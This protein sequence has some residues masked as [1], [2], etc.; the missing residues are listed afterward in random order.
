MSEEV[1]EKPIEKTYRWKPHKRAFE[2]AIGYIM[3]RK[4]GT[5]TSIRTGWPKVNDAIADGVEWNSTT[6]IAGRPASGKTL[7][8]DQLIRDAFKL[9]KN[10]NFR[11][12]EFQFEMVG[13]V[14]AMRSFSS[15]LDKSYKH[16]CSADG[17]IS[18]EDI[19]K[20]ILNPID[21]VDEPCTVMELR[22]IIVEYMMLHSV[23]KKDAEGKEY[24]EFTK[25]II[26]LDHSLL[27]KKAPFEKD[28]MDTLFALGEMLTA[29]KRMFPIAFIIL[30]QLNREIDK[31]E[32]NEE[33]KY[34]NYILESDLYGADAL[35]Q[36]ADTVIGVDRPGKR[37][38][39]IYGPD[40]YLIEDINVLIF[41]FLKARNGDTRLSFMKA[42]FHKMCVEEMDTPGTQELKI[43]TRP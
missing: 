25:T 27:V 13:R 34:G 31:P 18:N 17:V 5:I 4:Q 6:V 28:R 22:D 26:T 33:G 41:H 20:C 40:K 43:R 38:L 1:A 35:L 12:L 39:W 42:A 19:Q 30:S 29:L 2:E 23:I 9:N 32:R 11:V 10:V 21:V 7:I 36:H 15:Y 37:K 8:K 16:L 14:S 24:R 3:G